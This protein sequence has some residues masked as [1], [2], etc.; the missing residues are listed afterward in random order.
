V[1]YP[2]DPCESATLFLHI[3]QQ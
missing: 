3:H 1:I 2:I